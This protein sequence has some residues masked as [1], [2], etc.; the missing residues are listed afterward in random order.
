MRI[1]D[2]FLAVPELILALAIAALLGPS[3][4]QHHH[5]DL[6]P[7]LAEVR[8]HHPRADHPHQAERVRRRREGDRR[9]QAGGSTARTSCRTRS[10]RWSC[11]RRWRWAHVV[12]FAATLS[13]IGLAEAGLAEWGNLVSE[14]REGIVVRP[15]VG[16][17]LRRPDGVPLV[18]GLQPVRRR[19]ARRARPADG[20]AMTGCAWSTV[21]RE[22]AAAPDARTPLLSVR[23]LQVHFDT[24]RG[25]VARGR[26]RELRHP[27]GRDARAGRRDRLGEERHRPIAPAARAAAAGHLRRRPGPVP[28]QGRPA[29]RA[30]APAATRATAI[31]PRH[32]AAA[33][34]ARAAGCPACAGTGQRDRRPARRPPIAGC[35][36]IRGNHIAMIFQDPGKAL[37][38]G[39]DDPRP[40]G[41]GLRRAPS[42]RDSCP[43]PGIDPDARQRRCCAATP[44]ARSRAPRTVAAALAAAP[45]AAQAVRSGARRADRRGAGRHAHPQPPQGH[46]ALSARAVRRHEAARDDRPG[47]RREPGAADRRRADHRARRHD[48]GAHPRPARRAAGAHPHGGPLHQPRPLARAADQRTASR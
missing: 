13:F 27:R 32:R 29:R 2:V 7:G 1:V 18:A 35:G 31:G 43:R 28:P 41:R 6:G 8:P 26:R 3:F 24:K 30:T 23:D 17:D 11:R 12:L 15:L 19:S 37:N 25:I 45:P 16:R 48:P 36:S 47:A 40:G 5:R 33:R 10:R 34:R 42:R 14:G 46:A 21:A 44:G 4:T 22:D 39:A 38:P 20:R 9:L